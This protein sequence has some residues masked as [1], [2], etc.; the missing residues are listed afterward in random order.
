MVFGEIV[1]GPLSDAI[2]R[3]PAILVGLALFG[4][5]AVVA[6][7]AEPLEQILIGRVIQGIGCAGPQIAARALIHDPSQARGSARMLSFISL[8]FI[9]IIRTSVYEGQR[10]AFRLDLCGLL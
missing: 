8:V 1:F 4:L 7:E 5:G 6:M 9:I 3:K 2:E 10:V